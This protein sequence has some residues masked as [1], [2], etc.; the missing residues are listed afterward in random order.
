MKIS[1][2]IIVLVSVGIS[3]N[4]FSDAMNNALQDFF[5]RQRDAF[6]QSVGRYNATFDLRTAGNG[7]EN[8][9]GGTRA[10]AFT[11]SFEHDAATGLLTANGLAEYNK[12]LTAI[13]S[14]N[15]SDWNALNLAYPD[16]QKLVSPQASLMNTLQG[17]PSHLFEGYVPPKLATAE[18]AAQEIEIYLKMLCR[19]VHFSDYGTGANTDDNGSGGSITQV[20]AD[21]LQSLGDAYQG[22]RDPDTETV[23]PKVLFR[24]NAYGNLLGYH[25]SQFLLQDTSP[26]YSLNLITH[27]PYVPVAQK[28]EFGVSWA[29]FVDMENGHTPRPYV[30]N[31]DFV[32][33]AYTVAGRDLGTWVHRDGPLELVLHAANFLFAHGFPFS[34]VLPYYNGSMPNEMGFTAMGAPDIYSALTVLANEACKAAWAQKWLAHRG[35][36]PEAVGGLVHLAKALGQDVGLHPSLLDDALMDL[37]IAHNQKQS[38]GGTVPDAGERLSYGDAST[39]LLAVMAPEGSPSHPTFPS[40]HATLSGAC[41]TILKAFFEGSTK[42]NS[43]VTPVKPNPVD[44]TALV[45]LT[46][47]PGEDEDSLTVESE[48]NKLAVNIGMGRNWLGFHFRADCE[49]GNKLGEEVAICWLMDQAGFY[50]EQAFTGFELTKFDGQKIRITHNAVINI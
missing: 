48:L 24:G 32:G 20:A 37:V 35:A 2:L 40:G 10:G 19:H 34:S 47:A 50:N 15:Q 43:K 17:C 36:R 44:S 22:P 6:E 29:D 30:L 33:E 45:A 5:E 23:T 8:D 7:D 28:R 3:T 12:M 9:F 13:A 41:V 18:G 26:L 4:C 31:H 25:V 38:D 42:I 16:S 21:I 14:G 49:L 46:N 1:R 11:K 39:Y 27:K